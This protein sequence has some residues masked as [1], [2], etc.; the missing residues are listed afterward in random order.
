MNLARIGKTLNAILERTASAFYGI[1]S[2]ILAVLMIFTF[3]D[4]VLRYFFSSP[5]KGDY[6]I[7]AFMMVLVIPSGLAL[8]ALQKKHIRVD[9]LT[10]FLPKRVQAGLSSFAYLIALGFIGFMVWQAAVYAHMIREAGTKA[11]SVPVPHWPF[12]IVLTIFPWCSRWWC[13]GTSSA[14][15][16]R[17][18]VAERRMSPMSP[19]EIGILGMGVLFLLLFL[20]VHVG[21]AL[22]V[23]GF[24]GFAAVSGLDAALGIVRIVPYSTFS[25][26]GLIVIPLFVLMGNFAFHSGLS[27]DLYGTARAWFGRIRGG[28][29]MAT[30]AACAAFAAVSGSSVATAATMGKIALP[31]MKKHKYDDGLATGTLAA[32]ALSAT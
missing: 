26:Y 8:T 18:F 3:V 13:C 9:V 23:V 24:V 25:N 1:G 12:V 29:A 30:I 28:L 7:S 31:E 11:S 22:G 10:M 20:G 21:I 2:G 16:R 14:T 6:E 15:S 17:P 5:I 27:G 19:A 32:G 4:V